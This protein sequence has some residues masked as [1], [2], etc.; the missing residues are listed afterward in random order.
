MSGLI[1]VPLL[2]STCAI[3]QLSAKL[4]RFLKATYVT[5]LPF[6]LVPSVMAGDPAS[7]LISFHG[8]QRSEREAF[9]PNDSSE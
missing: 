4:Q 6:R 9:F 7:V 8:I 2:N 1:V 3:C 5:E